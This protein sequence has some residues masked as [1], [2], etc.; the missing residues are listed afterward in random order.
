MQTFKTKRWCQNAKQKN[1]LIA[2]F[3]EWNG[4]PEPIFDIVEIDEVL[5]D[6][7]DNN[8]DNRNDYEFDVL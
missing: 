5:L 4:R 3:N 1:E 7:I 6:G 2:K 8:N